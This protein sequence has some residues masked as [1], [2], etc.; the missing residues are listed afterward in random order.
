M[1]IYISV[2]IAYEFAAQIKWIKGIKGDV[3]IW[4]LE[5]RKPKKS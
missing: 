1:P 5:K 3:V 4:M 2:R